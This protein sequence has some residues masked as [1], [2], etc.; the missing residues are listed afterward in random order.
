MPRCATSIEK[1]C[2][3]DCNDIRAQFDRTIDEMKKIVE[4]VINA[5]WYIN[6]L[7][8]FHSI[9]VDIPS[10]LEISE[11][12]WKFHVD[13]TLDHILSER[14]AKMPEDM[15]QWSGNDA[16]INTLMNKLTTIHN[17]ML[18]QPLKPVNPDRP[19]TLEKAYERI[20]ELQKMILVAKNAAKACLWNSGCEDLC[21]HFD[22][23][24]DIMNDCWMPVF[25]K[26]GLEALKDHLRSVSSEHHYGKT[27][28]D[29]VK[30]IEKLHD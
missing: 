5:H 21:Y 29:C 4:D 28:E 13:N 15:T 11:Q 7:A 16:E 20:D 14:L 17:S 3:C 27:C 25:E 10:S 1:C 19:E 9:L 24:S 22:N 30:W 26:S 23:C 18:T 8:K 12:S 2:C 6:Q